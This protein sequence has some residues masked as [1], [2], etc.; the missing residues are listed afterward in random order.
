MVR[1]LLARRHAEYLSKHGLMDSKKATN[2]PLEAM[3]VPKIKVKRLLSLGIP[4]D[5]A[6]EWGNTRKGYWRIA[7][8]PILQRALDNQYWET[9]GLNS[10]LDGYNSLRN[11]S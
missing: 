6:F 5:K 9:N 10:L 8:S 3:E 4:K 1:L 7:S 2:V 11:I